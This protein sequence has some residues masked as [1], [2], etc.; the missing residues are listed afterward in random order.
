MY[1]VR[2]I[3]ESG[4]FV[5]DAFVEELTERTITTP[6]PDG[7]YWP[8][9]DGEKW[10]EGGSPP[11]L[12]PEQKEERYHQRVVE[13]I[14]ERY[15]ENDELALLRKKLAGINDTEFDE[16]NAFVEQ[17]KQAAREEIY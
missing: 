16:Y 15:S 11:E 17:C 6:C 9:W 4:L 2:I 5:E 13:L 1:F 10:V 8:R 7:F 14:R 3:D 12:T